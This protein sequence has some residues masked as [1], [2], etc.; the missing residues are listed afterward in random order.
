MCV[1]NGYAEHQGMLGDFNLAWRRVA[2]IGK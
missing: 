2:A 1:H